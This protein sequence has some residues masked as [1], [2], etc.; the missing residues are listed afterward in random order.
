MKGYQNQFTHR[1]TI[2]F[3]GSYEVFKCLQFSCQPLYIM[4]IQIELEIFGVIA[5]IGEIHE[6]AKYSTIC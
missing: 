5:I 6:V 2:E 1:K 4:Y 3:R